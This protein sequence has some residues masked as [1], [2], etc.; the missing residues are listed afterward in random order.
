MD[1]TFDQWLWLTF[2]ALC[3]GLSKT[4]LHGLGILIVPILAN[5]LGAKPSTGFV[6]PMLI[7]GDIVGVWYYHRHADWAQL[8]KLGPSTLTGILIALFVGNSINAAQFRTLLGI[9]ILVGVAIMIWR[10]VRNSQIPRHPLFAHTMGSMGGFT[11]MIGNA[12][13]PIMAIYLMAM[14]LPKNVFIGTAAWFYLLVNLFKMPLHILY[15]NT[16][17][18]DTLSINALLIVPIL[19]GAAIGLYI[20]KRIPERPFKWLVILS[21]IAAALKMFL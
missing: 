12:A 9:V 21:V 7:V 16:I 3:V 18:L 8:I 6:L 2:C 10:T 14:N 13:G 4:G 20:V 15:W 5:L 17:N 11:T 19:L 1:F